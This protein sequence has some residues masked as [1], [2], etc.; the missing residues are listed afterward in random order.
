M[1]ILNNLLLLKKNFGK[2]RDFSR[3]TF[4]PHLVDLSTSFLLPRIEKEGGILINNGGRTECY[5]RET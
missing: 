5:M 4:F 3:N 2:L 1:Q